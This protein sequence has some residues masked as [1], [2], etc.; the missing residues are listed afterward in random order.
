MAVLLLDTDVISFLLKSDTRAELY[1]PYLGRQSLALCFMTVA[2]LFQWAAVRQWGPGRT[3]Q[4]E[5]TLQNY[6]VLPFDFEL[7]RHW[8]EIRAGCRAAGQPISP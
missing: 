5:L 3:R 4:L 8:G 1:R 7:C 2:E 6:V